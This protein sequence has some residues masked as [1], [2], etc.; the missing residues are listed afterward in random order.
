MSIEVLRNEHA[1][2]HMLCQQRKFSRSDNHISK[3]VSKKGCVDS[4]T[5]LSIEKSYLSYQRKSKFFHEAKLICSVCHHFW[6]WATYTALSF[7]RH[8]YLPNKQVNLKVSLCCFGTF[9]HPLNKWNFIGKQ[10]KKERLKSWVEK[11]LERGGVYPSQELN[12]LAFLLVFRPLSRSP[13]GNIHF[14]HIS[15]FKDLFL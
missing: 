12:F 13:E 15:F 5:M 7:I 2:K 4:N 11:R 8:L 10:Q 9:Q 3:K 6:W 1:Y 14:W